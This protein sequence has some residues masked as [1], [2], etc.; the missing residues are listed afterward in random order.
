MN[1]DIK[2]FLFEVAPLVKFLQKGQRDEADDI[3]QKLINKY[4]LGEDSDDSLQSFLFMVNSY[5][6]DDSS[7]SLNEILEDYTEL[8]KKYLDEKERLSIFS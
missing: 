6:I 5:I 4:H 3:Y 2:K 1:E 7:T 8:T